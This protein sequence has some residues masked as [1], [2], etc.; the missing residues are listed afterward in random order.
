MMKACKLFLAF[1]LALLVPSVSWADIIFT[2]GNNPQPNEEN[3]LLNN[4]Q[5]GAFVTGTLN[6]SGLTVEFTS[7]SGNGLLTEPASG[8]A[9]IEGATGNTP[10]SQV[11]FFLANNATFD[12]AIFN[13]FFGSGEA[14]IAVTTLDG[15]FTFNSALG[16]GQNFFTVVASGGEHISLISLSTAGS[17]T[18]LRQVRISGAG[19]TTVPDSGSTL[20][21]FGGGLLAL[22]L[23]RRKE[24]RA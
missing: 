16:N 9:R 19:V 10:L 8:Q 23:I 4:G 14:T 1:S 24:T 18:D 11:S 13:M 12:D 21:F 15:V 20:S 5:T 2:I 22:A 6:Q 3:V 17:F 7:T